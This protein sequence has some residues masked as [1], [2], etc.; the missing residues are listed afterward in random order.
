[1]VAR[2]RSHFRQ[3]KA[4]GTSLYKKRPG[5]RERAHLLPE[6]PRKAMKSFASD[7]FTEFLWGLLRRCQTLSEI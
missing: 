6:E 4:S 7:R 2:I 5:V 1:M 3:L